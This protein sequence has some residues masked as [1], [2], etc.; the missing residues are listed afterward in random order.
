MSISGAL[1]EVKQGSFCSLDIYC[2][3]MCLTLNLKVMS[4]VMQFLPTKNKYQ[5]GLCFSFLGGLF[6]SKVII[7]EGSGDVLPKGDVN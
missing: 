7:S 5:K 4:V 2:C 1:G 3:F 6:Q